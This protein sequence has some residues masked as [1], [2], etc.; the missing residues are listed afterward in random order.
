V[1]NFSKK[2]SKEFAGKIN[3]HTFANPNLKGETIKQV[4]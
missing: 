3:F 1:F 4:L 2:K